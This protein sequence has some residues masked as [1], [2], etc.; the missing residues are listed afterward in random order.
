MVLQAKK[1]YDFAKQ[2]QAEMGHSWERL[3]DHL[4]NVGFKDVYKDEKAFFD[5]FSKYVYEFKMYRN[6]RLSKHKLVNLLK[7]NKKV[8]TKYMIIPSE[9]NFVNA[10]KATYEFFK[11]ENVSTS[12]V[13]IT[14]ILM[15]LGGKTP[16]YDSYF[17]DTFCSNPSFMVNGIKFLVERLKDKFGKNSLRT[18]EGGNPIPWE[19]VLDMGLWYASYIEHDEYLV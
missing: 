19:R 2:Y 18:Q 5:L 17:M 6:T 9:D 1:I 14:K 7:A 11:E 3:F 15:G 8:Y 13:M 12:N 16:A 4:T 10:W